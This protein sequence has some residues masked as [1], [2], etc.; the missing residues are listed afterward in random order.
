MNTPN[1]PRLDLSSVTSDL[2]S[3]MFAQLTTLIEGAADDV[4]RWVGEI[5]PAMTDAIA[6]GDVALTEELE[7]Q[8]KAVA[9]LN[10]LRA[11]KAKWA[12]VKSVAD[13]AMRLVTSGISVGLAALGGVK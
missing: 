8:M 7:A 3:T 5:V 6:N 11:I 9:E 10:N 13:S 4:R 12:V 1:A 2:K